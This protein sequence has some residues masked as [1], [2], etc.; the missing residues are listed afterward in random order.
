MTMVQRAHAY[1]VRDSL[2]SLIHTQQKMVASMH[3]YAHSA[4]I[5]DG[6]D[7][8]QDRIPTPA[9]AK[10]C[11]DTWRHIAAIY[12]EFSM[13]LCVVWETEMRAAGQLSDE[14]GFNG[15]PRYK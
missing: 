7:P 13:N 4:W 6:G 8:P 11:E 1:N 12:D 14:I 2:Q 5:W 3:A 15:L 9:N 10:R